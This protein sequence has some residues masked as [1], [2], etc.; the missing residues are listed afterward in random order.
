ML[1][2]ALGNISN[3]RRGVGQ[4]RKGKENALCSRKAQESEGGN[5]GHNN[6][7]QNSFLDLLSSVQ[8]LSRV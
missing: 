8:S 2:V 7:R 1:P 6:S 4:R 3:K 5:R